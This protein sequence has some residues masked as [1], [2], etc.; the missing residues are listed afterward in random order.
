MLEMR[1]ILL[2]KAETLY[3]NSDY[4]FTSNIHE[5][6]VVTAKNIV[7][8][9]NGYTLQGPGYGIGIHLNIYSWWEPNNVIIKNVV[10]KNWTYGILF[11][12]DGYL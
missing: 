10:I 4:T 8:D 2:A 12:V 6:I 9:G 7:I 3:I 5:P 11:G 1:L